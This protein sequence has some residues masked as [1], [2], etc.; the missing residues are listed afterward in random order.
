MSQNKGFGILAIVVVVAVIAAFGGG[1]YYMTKKTKTVAI[2][3]TSATTTF[4]A[5]ATT[6]VKSSTGIQVGPFATG[7]I[8]AFLNAGADLECSVQYSTTTA[9][10]ELSTTGV[11]FVSGDDM[12]GDFTM[13]GKAAV[14]SDA[15]IIRNGDDVLAWSGKQGAKL[16]LSGFSKSA[17]ANANPSSQV[18][19]DQSVLYRCMDWK[20]DEAKFL[21]PT[22]VT[23]F[24]ISNMKINGFEVPTGR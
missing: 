21:P 10:G 18:D 2:R 6:S 22:E 17:S 4:A 19:L 16:T 9:K 8:R 12:R 1:S 24:D 7:D 15:H 23:I 5:T 20:R 11:I 13:T 14:T 3:D